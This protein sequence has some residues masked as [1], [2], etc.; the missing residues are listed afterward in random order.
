MVST[1]SGRW[2]WLTDRFRFLPVFIRRTH[3]IVAAIWVVSLAFGLAAPNLAEQLPGPS[4]AG[5]SFIALVLTGAY[6]LIRPWVRSDHT[7][8]DR[9]NRLKEWDVTRPVMIR[10]IHRILGTLLLI[11]IGIALALTAVGA[12]ESPFVLVP[13]VGLLLVALITGGY[14]FFQPWVRRAR[15]D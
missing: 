8:S 6:L 3:R 5:L 12:G 2:N 11:F 10:R 13:I 1:I 4:I 9:W 15:A 14:M 7:V